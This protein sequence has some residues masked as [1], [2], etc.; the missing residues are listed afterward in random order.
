MILSL[1]FLLL[2][3]LKVLSFQKRLMGPPRVSLCVGSLCLV[4]RSSLIG[5]DFKKQ[6]RQWFDEVT[7]LL[8]S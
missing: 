5:N 2:Y 4:A 8:S 6:S 7:F 3:D 1:S